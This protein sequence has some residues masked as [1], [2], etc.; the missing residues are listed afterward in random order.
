M[1]ATQ[2]GNS[3]TADRS[4]FLD[5]PALSVLRHMLFVAR[6][7]IEGA[8]SG[9]HRSRQL[10]GSTE[11]VDYREYAPGE[12]LR[13]LDWKVLGR[14]GKP[15]IRIYQ[16]ETNLRCTLAIDASNSMRFGGHRG[17]SKLEYVQWLATGM[18][19]VIAAQQDQVGLASLG[20]ALREVIPPA[21]TPTHIY[22]LQQAIE[23]LKTGTRKR[24]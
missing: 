22:Q 20:G 14:T 5:T 12:D 17:I 11:F 23:K 24:T 6:G 10:G 18:S 19:S 7:R 8:F 21:S 15:V 1:A 4:R 3:T 2:T 13:R 16:D 9:R